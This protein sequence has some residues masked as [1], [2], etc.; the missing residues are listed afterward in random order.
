MLRGCARLGGVLATQRTCV[1]FLGAQQGAPALGTLR[2]TMIPWPSW[3]P[4][5]GGLALCALGLGGW[6]KH[7]KGTAALGGA[8]YLI[9]G[10]KRMVLFAG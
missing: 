3:G 2:K 4:G 1:A 8:L 9:K 6:R 7:E 5:S 10:A